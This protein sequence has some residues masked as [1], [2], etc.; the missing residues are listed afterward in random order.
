ML[1]NK[2]HHEKVLPEMFHFNGHTIRF[3]PQTQEAQDFILERYSRLY[4]EIPNFDDTRCLPVSHHVKDS[5]F[6]N[7]GKFCLWNPEYSSRNPESIWRL[8]S[9]I[10]LTNTG[11]EYLESGIQLKESWI[12]LKIGIQNPTDKHW[13]RV[14]GIW[15]TT[16]GIQNPTNDWNPESYWQTLV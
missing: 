3:H 7:L 11:I 1:T 9:R 16:L 12:P 5:G 8:E 14:P 13:N 4:K 6:R 10:L 2:Q 15:N